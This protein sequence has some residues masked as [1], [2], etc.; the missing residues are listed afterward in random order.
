MSFTTNDIQNALRGLMNNW[1]DDECGNYEEIY[2]DEED[3]RHHIE[4]DEGEEKTYDD[5]DEIPTKDLMEHNYK[6]LRVLQDGMKQLI[7][8]NK[9]LKEDLFLKEMQLVSAN[10]NA[11]V[12]RHNEEAGIILVENDR[13]IEENNKLKAENKE[14]QE[15][16]ETHFENG[17]DAGREEYQVDQEFLDE[18]DEEIKELKEQVTKMS[19]G[20]VGNGILPLQKE[21]K[22][23]KERLDIMKA[24][25]S[26]HI[27][28]INEVH[29]EY[30]DTVRELKAENNTRKDIIYNL[31][32]HTLE[33][34]DNLDDGIDVSKE[35][36]Q[37]YIDEWNTIHKEIY[38]D[39]VD[40]MNK[41]ELEGMHLEY[42][43]HCHFDICVNED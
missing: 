4:D 26:T 14:L 19:K 6:D 42:D 12:K 20:L 39:V 33:N 13:L 41:S 27:Q 40:T 43:G 34:T 3:G 38:T 18:K 11:D 37:K 36:G 21:N 9:K 31:F 15:Q 2:M 30:G 25:A 22:K 24:T 29:K 5:A 16:N 1:Y 8:E 28:E 32:A 10:E 23:L 35:Y 17:Y 7:E